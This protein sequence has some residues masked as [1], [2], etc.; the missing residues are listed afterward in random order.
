LYIRSSGGLSGKSSTNHI[1][2]SNMEVPTACARNILAIKSQRQNTIVNT[3][4]RPCE[5]GCCIRRYPQRAGLPW[6]VIA[7]TAPA[8]LGMN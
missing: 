4:V 7:S 5:L 6:L 3:I 2:T 8:R 1:S